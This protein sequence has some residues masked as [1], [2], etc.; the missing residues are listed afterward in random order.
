M[1]GFHF[2]GGRGHTFAFSSGSPGDQFYYPFQISLFHISFRY[3]VSH[4]TA[5]F[6]LHTRHR[7]AHAY[8]VHTY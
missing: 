8:D 3:L 7:C 1:G 6:H 5:N 2:G 4:V